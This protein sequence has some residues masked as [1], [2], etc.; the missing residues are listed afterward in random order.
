MKEASPSRLTGTYFGGASTSLGATGGSE[1]H[2]L[3]AVEIPSHTHAISDPGHVHTTT[4]NFL[5]QG[6]VGSDY[7]GGSYLGSAPVSVNSA[8][9][10]ISVNNTGGGGAHPNVQPTIIC[11]YIIRIL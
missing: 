6:L 2:T 4:G 10:G 5:K 9:T 8:T 1:R 7:T 3:T 11:N